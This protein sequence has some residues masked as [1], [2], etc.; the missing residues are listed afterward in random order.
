MFLES[1]KFS[2]TTN[3][4]DDMTQSPQTYIIA[5]NPEVLARLMKENENRIIN[6][7]AYTTPA[8]VFN[9]LAVDVDIT[10][11]KDCKDIALRTT[12]LPV[13]EFLKLDETINTTE[14]NNNSTQQAQNFSKNSKQ[15]LQQ[16][17]QRCLGTTSCKNCIQVSSLNRGSTLKNQQQLPEIKLQQQQ[18]QH[19]Q[20]QLMQQQTFNSSN[21][22]GGRGF[23]CGGIATFPKQ[24]H[25]HNY[26]Y[27]QNQQQ[28]TGAISMQSLPPTLINMSN[29]NN[30][31]GFRSSSLG[32][33]ERTQIIYD[34][35]RNSSN[36]LHLPAVIGRTGNHLSHSISSVTIPPAISATASSP[37]QAMACGSLERNPVTSSTYLNCVQKK[38]FSTGNSTYSMMGGSLERNRTISVN[39][40][41][42]KE[43]R[44]CIVPRSASLERSKEYGKHHHHA[45][46]HQYHFLPSTASSFM[47]F[48]NLIKVSPNTRGFAEETYKTALSSNRE[49]Y[50]IS[51]NNN[52]CDKTE[53]QSATPN[54]A[55]TY[56]SMNP[57][58]NSLLISSMTEINQKML[59]SDALLGKVLEEEE[60]FQKG[61]EFDINLSETAIEEVPLENGNST[62]LR[63]AIKEVRECFSSIITLISLFADLITVCAIV[64]VVVVVVW[65]NLYL[66]YYISEFYLLYTI[67]FINLNR[68]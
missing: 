1:A 45:H 12:K 17:V 25:I 5:Q 54:Y 11:S 7:A 34:F 61:L 51:N 15:H 68:H 10:K 60:H 9:T 57:G 31:G 18:Q 52:S 46:S 27:Q 58:G 3:L 41:V 36:K 64:F 13:R 24:N 55:G 53:N 6:P 30:S 2:G 56:I 44:R 16:Q 50:N 21:I 33:D 48:K 32:T 65:L 47:A 35:G 59:G 14:N 26:Y 8:S 63:F 43:S 29:P 37:G 4:I 20:Q 28:Y 42:G 39:S 38:K 22:S 66:F 49:N 67:I 62:S 23:Q 19:K 40:P